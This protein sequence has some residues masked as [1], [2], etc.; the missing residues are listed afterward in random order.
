MSGSSSFRLDLYQ[1]EK[2]FPYFI[3]VDSDYRISAFG[4]A[5][6]IFC[7]LKAQ[8]N[9]FD[10]FEI[11]RPEQWEFVTALQANIS[12]QLVSIP[13]DDRKAIFLY[14]EFFSDSESGD[15]LFTGN[16]V[17]STDVAYTL[18]SEG[19]KGR[20]DSPKTD[21]VKRNPVPASAMNVVTQFAEASLHGIAITDRNGLIQW[22]N[23]A[24]E[25]FTGFVL[26]EVIGLRPRQVLYGKNSTHIAPDYVDNMVKSGK[27]FSFENIGYKRRQESF[28]FKTTVQ[29]VFD[30]GNEYSGR[31]YLFQDISDRKQK[32][33]ALAESEHLLSLAL[34]G[35]GDGV[36]TI[37][38]SDNSITLSGRYKELLGFGASDTF[39]NLPLSEALHPEDYSRFM[40]LIVPEMSQQQPKFVFEHRERLI[41]GDY[42]SFRARGMAVEWNPDGLPNKII[43][44]VTDIQ[45]QK[46]RD[47]QIR[48][49]YRRLSV[50]LMSMDEAIVLE[51]EDNTILLVNSRLC[52]LFGVV[53]SPD[54]LIGQDGTGIL[55]EADI[56]FDHETQFRERVTEIVSKREKVT[57]ELL[58]TVDGRIFERQFIPIFFDGVYRGHLWTYKDV[59]RLRYFEQSLTQNKKLKELQELR[60][61]NLLEVIKDAVLTCKIDGT[62]NFY[63][64]AFLQMFGV[65][66]GDE[67][68]NLH[69]YLSPEQYREFGEKQNTLFATNEMQ[70]GILSFPDRYLSYTLSLP[71]GHNNE[72]YICTFTD[73]SEIVNKEN[74]LNDIIARQ[75]ELNNDKSRFIRITSHELRTPLSIIRANAEIFEMIHDGKLPAK[76]QTDPDKLINRII[77][78]VGRMTGILDQL[79]IVSR[80]E[81]GKIEFRTQKMDV[82]R[83]L[84]S[85]REDFYDPF[86]DGRTLI[87]DIDPSI[88]NIEIDIALVKHALVNLI[89]NAFKYSLACRPPELRVRK[90]LGSV[91]FEIEDFGIGIPSEEI[92]KLFNSFYRASNVGQIQGTGLGLM[93]T[94]YAVKKHQGSITLTSELSKGSVF[95]IT[96]PQTYQ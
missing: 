25:E 1:I 34:E 62:L 73:I 90:G 79:M 71:A 8:K 33:F 87:M 35:T 21:F 9:L 40:R 22:V 63:N 10:Y 49:F 17:V 88:G 70:S 50:L 11:K 12:Y 3:R 66:P 28:W 6:G 42:K 45:E 96:L 37:D 7:G 19:N 31:I 46:Q 2:L 76:G 14:G 82:V 94:E 81:T 26:E 48:T 60:F 36:F 80:I 85:I 5:L 69:N 89:N 43:G 91:V 65:Q 68:L 27:P 67:E 30:D 39:I 72:I 92:N 54:D 4:H 29:P 32:E 64:P 61:R 78:E 77:K 74:N 23:T 56:L 38:L 44:T 20:K 57:G 53:G 75:T 55:K 83:F 16:L 15:L 84:S 18:K 52:D 41:N 86:P 59:T 93:I 58:N 47:E 24:F 51:S 95:T 13:Q